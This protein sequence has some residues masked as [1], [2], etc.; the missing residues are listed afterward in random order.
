MVINAILIYAL[1]LVIND[2]I[3]NIMTFVFQLGSHTKKLWGEDDKG[4]GDGPGAKGIFPGA[5]PWT[6]RDDTWGNG[7]SGQ[8]GNGMSSFVCEGIVPIDVLSYY[9]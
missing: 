3:I 5:N 9:F 8:Y 6:T 2:S 1:P 4:G 7:A